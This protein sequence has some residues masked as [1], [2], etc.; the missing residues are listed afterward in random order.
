MSDDKS[1]LIRAAKDL[2]NA[3]DDMHAKGETFTA[4]V[5]IAHDVLRKALEKMQ[6]ESR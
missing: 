5:S 6:D 3:I 1:K 2:L 4:R